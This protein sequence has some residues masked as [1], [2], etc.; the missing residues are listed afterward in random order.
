MRVAKVDSMHLKSG[1]PC[2]MGSMDAD[3]DLMKRLIT[4]LSKYPN[5]FIVSKGPL[6]EQIVLS[7]NM[8]G[9]QSVPQIDIL[10]IVDLV[11]THGGNN[12]IT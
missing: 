5:K 6:H 4:I 2:S 12:T 10:S 3:F 11:I 8:W 9:K 7:D 1:H